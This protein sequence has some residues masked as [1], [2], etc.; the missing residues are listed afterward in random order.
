MINN[1]LVI[2]QI[3]SPLRAKMATFF[4]PFRRKEEEEKSVTMGD[5]REFTDL[6]TTAIAEA[7]A[8]KR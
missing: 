3:K 5:L 7:I 2:E 1:P 6:L 8:S 4:S